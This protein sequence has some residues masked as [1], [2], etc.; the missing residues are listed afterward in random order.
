M[1]SFNLILG[2]YPTD[3]PQTQ[4]LVL[5]GVPPFRAMRYRVPPCTT[6]H[7]L[8]VYHRAESEYSKGWNRL[9]NW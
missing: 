4:I 2:H 5:L 8:A 3:R 1:E 7:H 9:R 6:V